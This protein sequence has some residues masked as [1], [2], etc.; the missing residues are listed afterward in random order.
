MK[1]K[2]TVKAGAVTSN[3]NQMFARGPQVSA[4]LKAG[5][6]TSNHNQTAA[7]SLKVRSNIKAGLNFARKAGG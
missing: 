4:N 5:S 1:V 2:T 7:C 3:H 6:L